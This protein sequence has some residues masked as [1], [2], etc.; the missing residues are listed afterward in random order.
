MRDVTKLFEGYCK[1]RSESFQPQ[2]EIFETLAQQGQHPHT[3]V[4][5]CCDSRVD[6]SAVFSAGLGELFVLRNVANLIPPHEPHGDFHGTS[7]AIDFAV[8][9]LGVSDIVILGHAG[10]G[11]IKA[12]LDGMY[13]PDRGGGIFIQ[14]WMSLLKAARGT[15]IANNPD[16]APDVL[17]REL[18]QAGVVSSLGNL[19]SFAFVAERVAAGSLAVHGAYFDIASGDLQTYDRKAR[20]FESLAAG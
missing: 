14:K 4:I 3:M 6:P 20:C 8:N 5:G 10:C 9:G 1:F 18:E 17:Q 7:A 11:G 15:V 2:R 16:Q 13:E 19:M 12:Y